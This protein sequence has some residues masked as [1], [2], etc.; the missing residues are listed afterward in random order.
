MTSSDFSFSKFAQ[1]KYY[2]NL[3]AR[4]I[5]MLD[6]SSGQRIVDLACGTGAIIKLVLDRLRNARDSVVIGVD[7]S[8]LA[9]NKAM[10][11]LSS[12][13][14]TA[15]EFIQSRVEQISQVIKESADTI[16]FCNGIHYIPDKDILIDEVR[17]VLRPGGVFAFNTSFFEGAHP[18]ESLQFYRRWMIKAMKH[19]KSTYGLRPERGDKVQSRQHL[20]PDEYE[21]LLTQHGMKVKIKE[22]HTV[23][24]PLEG[25][26]AISQFKDFIS[27]IMP[28]VPL[29]KA[30]ASLKESVKQTY[31]ALELDFVPRNW[32]YV[33]AVRT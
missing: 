4:L 27:G 28:G 24:M 20:T 19:L 23:Q 30:S 7:Q 1:H 18:P 2:R 15:L 3:N 12:A 14:L 17:K 22:V 31:E 25:W 29:D 9:L 33:V 13:K 11:E 5:D 21:E 10:K 16:I 26:L 8:A 6:L 32:L